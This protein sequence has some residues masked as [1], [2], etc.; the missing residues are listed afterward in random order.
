MVCIE[1]TPD[2]PRCPP[3]ALQFA[4]EGFSMRLARVA[5]MTKAL[6]C[7]NVVAA[8]AVHAPVG[9]LHDRENVVSVCLP[10]L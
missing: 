5:S 2:D 1:R 7:S 6:A 10:L 8:P 3:L 9:A 4:L